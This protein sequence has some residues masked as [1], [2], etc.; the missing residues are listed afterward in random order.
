MCSFNDK[1]KI[2][3]SRQLFDN[4]QEL[5]RPMIYIVRLE[6]EKKSATCRWSISEQMAKY[7][8]SHVSTDLTDSASNVVLQ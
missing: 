6:P 2:E 8:T 7:D 1:R 5:S 4:V 3:P